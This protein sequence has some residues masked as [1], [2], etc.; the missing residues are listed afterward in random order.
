MISKTKTYLVL[1]PCSSPVVAATRNDSF[2]IP[3]GTK[4]TPGSWPLSID[5]IIQINSGSPLFKTGYLYFEPEYEAEIYEELRIRDWK[6]ILREDD[7]EDIILN[8]TVEKLQRIVDID[9]DFYFERVYGIYIGLKNANYAIAG[10][11]QTVF[12]ARHREFKNGKKKSGIV[13]TRKETTGNNASEVEELKARLHEMEEALKKMT[14]SAAVTTDPSDT[15]AD[16][17]KSVADAGD[18]KAENAAAKAKKSAAA[19]A[20]TSTPNTRGKKS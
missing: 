4:N 18:A 7:V 6:S 2:T 12:T 11:V 20:R 10:N 9:S 5:E 13:L 15:A 16:S 17:N 3:G 1:N 8:P 14:A 19:R